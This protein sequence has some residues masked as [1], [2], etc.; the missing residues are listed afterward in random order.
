[1]CC[2]PFL[3]FR[4][5]KDHK[6]RLTWFKKLRLVDPPNSDMSVCVRGEHFTDFCF[7]VDMQAAMGLRRQKE[8]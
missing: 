6:L 3:Q 2:E 5:A 4:L 7:I 8:A 1:M